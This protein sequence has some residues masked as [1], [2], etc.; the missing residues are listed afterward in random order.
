MKLSRLI[1]ILLFVFI[2]RS[3]ADALRELRIGRA[4]HAFD[5]LGDIGN[6]A[7]AASAC[8]M[9]IIYG[10]G[11]GEV[12]Y[13]GLPPP[14]ELADKRRATATYVRH[15]KEKGIRLAIGYVCATS[16]VKLETFDKNWPEKFRAQFSSVPA[17]WLQQD[18]NG[19]PL[20]SWYGGDYRPAC[21][22]NPD[23]RAYEKF[24]VRQQLEAGYDGIFFDNPTVHQQGC[25]CRY[26]AEKFG[27]FLDESGGLSK[28]HPR[29]LTNSVTALRALAV[30]R[31]NDFMRFRSTIARDFFAEIR[32]FARTIKPDALITANNSLNRSDLLFSQCRD[33][34]YNIYEMSKTEDFVVVEDMS[35][36]PRRHRNGSLIEYGPTYKQLEAISHGKPI[37]AVT[38]ADDGLGIPS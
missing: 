20:P 29:P 2:S 14:K 31:P 15:A 38:L 6:Q 19:K 13:H 16:M 30:S 37:V 18:K 24:I 34:G 12:G 17:E 10:T 36:Q 23:W 25:Y 5:H 27:S 21:M 33:L 26:C 32:C 4:A 1:L 22:N 28:L 35:S 8:G 9:T 7:D 3:Q 11:L